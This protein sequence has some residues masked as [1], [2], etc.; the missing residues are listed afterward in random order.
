MEPKTRKYQCKADM[1]KQNEA[2]NMKYYKL[3]YDYEKGER[4]IDCNAADLQ[5]IDILYR[6][7]YLLMN[8]NRL[9]MNTMAVRGL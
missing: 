4:Y 8:G 9:Y 6:V 3:M 1:F 5:G 2:E 7:E